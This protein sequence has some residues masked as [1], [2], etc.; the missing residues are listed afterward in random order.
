MYVIE[1]RQWSLKTCL[2]GSTVVLNN[3]FKYYKVLCVI[4]ARVSMMEV[5]ED[6]RT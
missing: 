1:E 3:I 6:Q 2:N 4:I 5:S